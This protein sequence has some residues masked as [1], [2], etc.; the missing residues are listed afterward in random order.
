MLPSIPEKFRGSPE[1]ETGPVAFF[2]DLE[3]R[4]EPLSGPSWTRVPVASR[5][6]V[7]CL[8]ETVSGTELASLLNHDP[9]KPVVFVGGVGGRYGGGYGAPADRDGADV[10]RRAL[11]DAHAAAVRLRELRAVVGRGYTQDVYHLALAFAYT[12]ENRVRVSIGTDRP[13]GYFY[14]LDVVLTGIG[15]EDSDA[16]TLLGSLTASGY[17]RQQLAEIAHSCPTCGSIQLLL[18]DACIDCGSPSF[19]TVDIVHHFRCGRQAPETEFLTPARLYVCPKCRRELRHFG[20]DYDKPGEV[21]VCERCGHSGAESA[22]HGRCL[23]CRS[24]FLAAT[25]PKLRLYDY[26]LTEAGIHAVLSGQARVFDPVRLLGEHLPLMPLDMLFVMARKLVALQSRAGVET[27]MLSLGCAEAVA[28]TRTTGEEIRLLV[29]IG[30]ELVKLIRETDVAAYDRG[31]LYLL[32]PGAAPTDADAVR[33]RL[34]AAL[35]T[36]F[37]EEVLNLLQWRSAPADGF[38]EPDGAAS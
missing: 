3:K 27:L 2:W 31:N 22:V 25:A 23:A 37:H 9:L 8:D 18:R 1:R 28:R 6:E 15:S 19:A 10:L 36:V 21:H 4:P 35:R 20:L 14:D 34:M 17:L 38:L 30:I 5:A 12:R 26:E 32:M 33:E 13:R 29:R 16:A 7:L 24:S 11:A